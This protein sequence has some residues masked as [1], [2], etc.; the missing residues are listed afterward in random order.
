MVRNVIFI[1]TRIGKAYLHTDA[2]PTRPIQY[3]LKNVVGW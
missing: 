3:M 2:L 1:I